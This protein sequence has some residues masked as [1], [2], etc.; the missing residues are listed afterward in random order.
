MQSFDQDMSTGG[1][2]QHVKAAVVR[3]EGSQSH[4]R[5]TGHPVAPSPINESTNKDPIMKYTAHLFTSIAG[6]RRLSLVLLMSL[7]AT[8]LT[9]SRFGQIISF[10]DSLSDTGNL[11]ANSGG[12]VPPQDDY[13]GG[14]GRASNGILW[15]EYLAGRL[16]VPVDDY[17]YFGA[18][19]DDTNYNDDTLPFLLLGLR[20]Q[21]DLF[22]ADL[23]E[24]KVD[25]RDLFLIAIGANDFFAYLNKGGAFPITGGIDNTVAEVGRLLDAGARHVVVVN[26]PDLSSTPAF[27]GLP[28]G[29]KDDLQ[30]L[31]ATYNLFLEQ[32]LET[33]ARDYHANV[34]VVDAFAVLNDIIADPASYGMTNVTVPVG[35]FPVFDPATSLFWDGV[36]PTTAGHRLMAEGVLDAMLDHY[37]P[38]EAIGVDGQTPGWVQD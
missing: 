16:D 26:V 11:F 36:H 9:A 24:D 32:G 17:A 23:G 1:G 22:L 30:L 35:L 34:V 7:A 15:V 29:Q 28:Q 21:V 13:A 6:L 5:A 12:L 37:V 25:N 31:V 27:A 14:E 20:D 10:G 8:V 3:T 18:K 33:L 38:G 4:G 19:T 2:L